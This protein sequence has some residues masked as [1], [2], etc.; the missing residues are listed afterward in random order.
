MNATAQNTATMEDWARAHGMKP[1][2][3]L[4]D[5]TPTGGFDLDAG[6]APA[7]FRL[8]PPALKPPRGSGEWEEQRAARLREVE[9]RRAARAEL[10]QA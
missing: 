4:F 9:A 6:R 7:H 5:F 8:D 3:Q 1:T 10:N 2:A